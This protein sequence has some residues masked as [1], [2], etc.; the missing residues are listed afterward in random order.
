MPREVWNPA[1][2][3]IFALASSIL[4]SMSQPPAWLPDT[5]EIRALLEGILNRLDSQPATERS[6]PVG[7]TLN[8]KT[9]P[10][11]FAFDEQADLLW[12]QLCSL[13]E[14][15]GIVEIRLKKKRDPYAPEYAG[16]RLVLRD[17]AEAVLRE[18]LDR[19]AGLSPRNAWRKAVA[20]QAEHFPGST[21]KL[22]AHRIRVP[23][24]DDEAVVAGFVHIGALQHHGL[25]LRQLSSRC[26]QGDSKFLDNREALIRE[27]YPDLDIAPRPV[28]VNIYLPENIEGVLFIEN[29]DSY[30]LAV[31]GAIE[32]CRNRALVYVAGFRSSAVRI[33]EEAGVSLHYHRSSQASNQPQLEAWWFGRQDNGWTAGFWGDLDFAGMSILQA[34]RQRFIGLQ[35]W[36]PGYEPM[37]S[38]LQAG[39]G[40]AAVMA[41][42]QAQSDPGSTGC[43]YADQVLLP[44]LR[45]Y[46][47]FVDQEA[48]F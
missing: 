13:D 29:Q 15:H 3:C 5:P 43:A 42:K 20:G 41:G 7:M 2:T 32:A 45:Q 12:D 44:A 16:A 21:E 38:L 6:R 24:L 28:M 11:L 17:G 8:E 39:R 4:I 26:F 47:A 48:V 9:L 1:D 22:R 46:R 18:W 36:Q 34:L 40:H 37:L 23:G 25:S 27:L 35:A 33:R 30:A 19:P 31:S 10:A 14:V